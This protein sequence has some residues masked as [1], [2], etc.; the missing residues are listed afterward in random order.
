VAVELDVVGIEW[1]D[2]DD[3][4]VRSKSVAVVGDDRFERAAPV[5]RFVS[6]RGQRHHPGWYWAATTTSLV[7]FESWLERDRLMMLD[8]DPRVTGIAS[9][10]F[11][12]SWPGNGGRR[13][14]VPDYFARMA[15]GSGLVI[16]VRPAD[17]VGERDQER[18]ATTESVC[19]Q[20]GC[21]TYLLLHEPDPVM[22]ANLR[23]LAGYRH[24]RSS[25]EQ[26]GARLLAVFGQERR[27]IEGAEAVGDPLRVL[28]VVLHLIWRGVLTVAL[29]APLDD[30]S[31][32]KA[33]GKRS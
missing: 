13:S 17:R 24:P 29:D 19:Q 3:G 14:H 16:D 23:W 5:R 25:S 28:P 4:Q 32:V 12:L 9:Q 31:M 7:G 15:D 22:M 8:H 10:P 21:W 20:L 27:L 1:L 2:G 26:I 6:Y 18:F 33:A 30:R 11:R